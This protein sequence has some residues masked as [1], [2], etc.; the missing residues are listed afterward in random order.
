M[1]IFSKM[2]L[3]TPTEMNALTLIKSLRCGSYHDI[4]I[5]LGKF[6]MKLYP[7]NIN[8]ISE[9]AV[10]AYYAKKYKQSYNLYQ[11]ILNFSNLNQEE[12]N[13]Y[14]FN[15]HF[16]IN[17][18]KNN[19]IYYDP[20]TVQ[21]ILNNRKGE[22]KT[23]IPLV[24]FS[25]T[26][27]KR[28]NLFE[29]TIN[30]FINCC[31]DIH[32]I[33]YWICVDDNS[34]NEDRNKMKEKYPFFTFYFKN[35]EEKGHPQSM[36]IIRN[37]VKEK[38]TEYNFHM[39]DD[40]L[41]FVKKSYISE[42]IDVLSCNNTIGQCLINK[43]YIETENDIGI[44]GGLFNT[45]KKGLR[46]YIHDYTPTPES[47][48]LFKKK[49]GI[50]K[51]S[52]YWPHYSLR[53]SL[54][55][56]SVLQNIGTYNEKVSHFEMEYSY[57]YIK[58]GYVSA[59][60]EEIYSIHIGRLTSQKDDKSKNVL[61]NAYEL[62]NELQLCGKEARL[63]VCGEGG[64]QQSKEEIDQNC[65]KKEL[66]L[67]PRCK[68][69]LNSNIKTCVVNL[70]SRPDRLA[71]FLEDSEIECDIFTAIYGK[72]LKPT[73]QLQQIFEGNDYNMR[74]GLVGCAMSHIKMFIN[75]VKSQDHD[76]LCIFEDD[77]K[78]VPDFKTKLLHTLNISKSMDWDMIYLG[79]H[80]RKQ[81]RDDECYNKTNMPILEKWSSR[82]SK[83]R[84]L[85]GTYGYLITKNGAKK[86][87]DFINETGMTNGIDTVQ[88][89]SADKLNIFY[90]YPHLVYSECFF[91]GE[92]IDT[93]IQHDFESLTI[94]YEKRIDLEKEFYNDYKEFTNEI[95]LKEYLKTTLYGCNHISL[96][97]TSNKQNIL[98]F[99]LEIKKT[100]HPSYII[101]NSVDKF[102]LII[103]PNPSENHLNNRYFNR[104]MKNK[105]F[106]IDDAIQAVS[107]PKDFIFTN[108]WFVRNINISM[109]LLQ[110]LYINLPILNPISILEIGSHEG[111]ST[112]WMLNN[113][114][115][116]EDSTITSIDPYLIGDITSPVTTTTYE[117]FQNNI[118]LCKDYSKFTQYVDFSNN[119]LLR[120]IEGN[121]KYDII[122]IDGSHAT[123]DVLCDLINSDKLI[124]QGGI[125][126]LD[127][128]GY[129]ETDLGVMGAIK[130]FLNQIDKNV[131]N[132]KIIL[133]EYQWALRAT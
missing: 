96:F 53:P 43:N 92:T 76:I 25:I 103:V 3:D 71:K 2:F 19:Y 59:F 105:E 57:R 7:H 82:L 67:T 8:I 80:L 66:I 63:I 4:N 95:E 15:K 52:S 117:L 100:L 109:K 23:K 6:L 35:I 11:K 13:S 16:S 128:V 64:L 88:Q 24:T 113:L 32:L 73:I 72:E 91:P 68:F 45:T 33:D 65:S 132:Y 44:L 58:L 50:G 89:N 121:K 38:N 28:Y 94:P 102:T 118:K 18:V 127:D 107:T 29:K 122:Y 12:S 123:E 26:T 101:S 30:S 54:V 39:E 98:N 129:N 74:V 51:N 42:C 62:N 126:L 37:F 69:K 130:Q 112:V 48:E 86:L 78:F 21:L 131:Y 85:G 10:S 114:C 31:I 14:I 108:D 17:Y 40:W 34:S 83:M 22:K 61:P 81:F 56:N 133:Q 84:S 70:N 27:C 125:I 5:I 46:Y 93:D 20:N 110:D 104:L 55:R 75:L 106:N 60:L 9:I 1:E 99:Q 90:C 47:Q 116:H 120:L 111:R 36:N 115:I 79:N 77:I 119:I 41:F 124:K 49:Y 97:Y 87:L